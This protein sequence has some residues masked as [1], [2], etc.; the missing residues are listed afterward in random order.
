M[1]FRPRISMDCCWCARVCLRT[2]EVSFR[3]HG[4]RGRLMKRLAILFGSFRPMRAVRIRVCCGLHFQSPPYAQGK[5]VRVVQGSVLDV[6]VD[7]RKDSKTYGAHHCA[8]LSED[9]RWQFWIPLRFCARLFDASRG[10]Q[11]PLP[12]HGFLSSRCRRVSQMG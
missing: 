10:H 3:K 12:L 9:N 11:V 5:L 8:L 6:A 4:I 1:K 2:S 7:L